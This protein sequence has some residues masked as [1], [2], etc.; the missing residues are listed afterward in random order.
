M[1][2]LLW[3]YMY[4]QNIYT[5]FKKYHLNLNTGQAALSS[6]TILYKKMVQWINVIFMLCASFTSEV[7]TGND[8]IPMFT[9]LQQ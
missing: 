7:R 6:C 5:V 3:L 2:Q 1:K 8:V 4:I 9:V